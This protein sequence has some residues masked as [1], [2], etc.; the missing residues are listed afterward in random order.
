MSDTSVLLTSLPRGCCAV[1]E[2]VTDRKDLQRLKS[3]GICI[4][5][6]VEITKCGDPLILK[7]YGTRVGLSARLADH[8]RVTPCEHAKRCWERIP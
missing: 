8:V 7:V 6:S 5:R 2:D 3:M 4:G 1:I